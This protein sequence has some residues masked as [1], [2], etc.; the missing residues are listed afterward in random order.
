MRIIHIL[1]A[2]ETGGAERSVYQLARFQHAR[3]FDVAVGFGQARGLFAGRV[4][5]ELIPAFD[6][7][8]RNG[9]DIRAAVRAW[10]VLRRFDVHHFHCPE[11]LL[12]SASLLC[13]SAQRIYTHRGGLMSYHGRHAL[14]YRL[15]GAQL[16]IGFEH[17][18]A[19]PQAARAAE[20]LF[21]IPTDRVVN[22]FN[23]IEPTNL[24]SDV[25]RATVRA[26][27]G[28][29]DDTILIGTAATLRELKRVDLLIEAAARLRLRSRSWKLVILGDGPDRDRLEALA[30]R[31]LG[32][33]EVAFVGMV[34]DIGAWLNALDIFSLASGPE[35]GFGNAVVEA[36]AFGLP[37]VVCADSPGL[38]SHVEAGVSGLVVDDIDGMTKALEQLIVRPEMRAALGQAGRARVLETY[39]M[40][41][42]AA[43]FEPLYYSRHAARV[44]K[45]SSRIAT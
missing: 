39:S 16:R 36:L 18:T 34:S 2:G 4:A 20:T 27:I 23:G 35:E 13:P 30:G 40:D 1:W 43:I 8:A 17:L 44:G 10:R 19:A 11:P 21:R 31:L 15:V 14:R 22:S 42:C 5:D 6:F 7:R 29:D 28:V 26:S 33:E 9:R 12:M 37:V 45:S 3:G 38:T 24:L 41:Q 25:P 32:I